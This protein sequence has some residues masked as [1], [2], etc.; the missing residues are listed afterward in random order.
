MRGNTNIKRSN[1]K[2]LF[3]YFIFGDVVLD[4]IHLYLVGI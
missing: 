2:D 3:V 1:S 4:Y